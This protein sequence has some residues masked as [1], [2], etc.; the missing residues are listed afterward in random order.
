MVLPLPPDRE[1]ASLW[2]SVWPRLRCVGVRRFVV[3]RY[4]PAFVQHLAAARMDWLYLVQ[5]CLEPSHVRLRRWLVHYQCWRPGAKPK[6]PTKPAHKSERMSPN[7]F[8][9]TM[10]SNCSGRITS[11]MQVLS[12]I[13]SW[14]SISG[15]WLATS[16][17]V[18]RNSPEV[19]LM[20]LALCTAVTFLRPVVRA[21]SNA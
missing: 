21:K 19:D 18:F 13:I 17:A 8:V 20:M 2:H 14:K 7:K 9:V 12:T 1:S 6:P 5:R 11:C 15:Y 4:D 3:D 10:M 16:R